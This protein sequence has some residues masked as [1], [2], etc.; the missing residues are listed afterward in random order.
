SGGDQALLTLADGSTIVLN[1][2]GDGV[3]AEQGN[4][5]IKKAADGSL[6]YLSASLF[7]KPDEIHD[8]T[9]STPAGGQYQI[10]LPDGTKVW[11]NATSSLKFPTAF[12]GDE[13]NVELSG[14]AYFEVSKFSLK[15][16][17]IPFY[18]NTSKSRIAVLGTQFN[19]MSYPEEDV[20]ETTLLEGSIRINGTQLGVENSKLLKPG[21]QAK[22]G[23]KYAD[24]KIIDDVNTEAVIGWKTG[25]FLFESVP[26]EEVMRRV[27]R[28]Y[29]AEVI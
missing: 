19:V 4:T 1:D 26:I 13:R 28:W 2:L 24:I 15:G 12:T 18:V 9:I 29:D 22:I 23:N 7:G 5:S 11:L 3:I 17:S 8:N 27:Q 25:V 10:T 16:K 14:E 21:Q 6:A 20:Q